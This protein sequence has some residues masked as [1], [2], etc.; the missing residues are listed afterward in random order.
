MRHQGAASCAPWPSVIQP[1]Q[2]LQALRMSVANMPALGELLLA[3]AL[4]RD[5][6]LAGKVCIITS[7]PGIGLLNSAALLS[8]CGQ[9][10]YTSA[11]AVIAF[12]GVH[13]RPSV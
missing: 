10:K 2:Q 3:G 13:M 9:L 6:Y 12:L 11:D 5:K 1:L 7:V 4:E 8:V